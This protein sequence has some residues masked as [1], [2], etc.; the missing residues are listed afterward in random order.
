MKQFYVYEWY[1]V[2]NNVIFY[3]GK[4]CGD[5]YKQTRVRN[6]LF[7]DYYKT[8]L[9]KV[10]IIKYFDDEREAFK[11]E[12][13]HIAELREKKEAF[14][15]ISE[16]G[17]GGLQFSWTEEM[18][19]YKSRFNPMKD[20]QQRI[21][22]SNNNPMKNQEIAKRVASKKSRPVIIGDVEYSSIKEACI[23]LNTHYETV[24]Y[25]C[26]RGQNKDGVL[27]RFKDQEQ[28]IF[29]GKRYNKGGC[30]PLIYKGKY[31]ESS[32]DLAEE[33]QI[34]VYNIY[35]WTKRGFDYDGNSCRYEDDTRELVYTPKYGGISKY[36]SMPVI[37]NGQ[38]YPTKRKAAKEL[39]ISMHTINEYLEGKRV[40]NKYICTYANQ[41]PSQGNTD[42]STLE[43]STTNG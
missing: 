38:Y 24:V 36:R 13:E 30:R 35:H 39:H 9:C 2:N 14:C 18:R 22:M 29:D 5:R 37:I 41:Q 26:K 31:Y 21:R 3:V 42:N 7:L 19:S 16:G 12:K 27:C 11:Y 40:D 43:G 32:I 20:Q 1:D 34:N 25:W 4:G 33:L 15:N 6:K 17:N 8:H 23:A 10:R 28:I